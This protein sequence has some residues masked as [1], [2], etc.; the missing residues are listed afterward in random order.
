VAAEEGAH[1]IA[2]AEVVLGEAASVVLSEP[3]VRIRKLEGVGSAASS[4]TSGSGGQSS[5]DENDFNDYYADFT[6]FPVQVS[7]LERAEGTIDELLDKEG[8]LDEASEQRWTAWMFQVIAGLSAAQHWFGF[9]H[10]DLHTNNI[11]WS[12][13]DIPYIYYK[14]HKSHVQTGAKQTAVYRVPTHGYILKIIDFGRASFTLP[15]P[16]GFFISDAFYPGNDAA[17][18]YNCEPFYDQKAGKKV[19]PNPSFDLCRLAVGML[20]SLFPK[21]PANATPIKIVGREGG[22]T[23][24][25]TTSPL[26]NLMWEW[27]TDDEGKNVL[28]EPDGKERYPDFDLYPAI[29]VGVHGAVP[30]AQIEKA[31][32]HKAFNHTGPIEG[33]APVYE[34]WAK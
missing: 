25:E 33:G 20:E 22:K 4:E 31:I 15:E 12:K 34:L 11:M 9:V 13:T 21:R 26:Y 24:A 7:L 8:V 29:A 17:F 19:E 5:A 16:Y 28:R 18:Q 1:T 3:A 32:F 6:D 14:V 10:N 27:L 2:A 30:A 23:Y